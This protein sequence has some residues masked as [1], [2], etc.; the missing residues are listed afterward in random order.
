MQQLGSTMNP[1]DERG[2]MI[3]RPGTKRR[4]VYNA[5]VEGKKAGEIMKE[6]GL[7][8]KAYSSHQYFIANT[9]RANAGRYARDHR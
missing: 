4:K 6:L 7:H 3:P 2:W 5:L 8:R 1:R 9:A